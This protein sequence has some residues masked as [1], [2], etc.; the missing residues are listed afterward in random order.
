MALCGGTGE[1]AR[2][3]P[4]QPYPTSISTTPCRP[5]IVRG[6]VRKDAARNPR[7]RPHSWTCAEK[8]TLTSCQ[9]SQI[10]GQGV[11]VAVHMVRPED[12]VLV[13]MITRRAIEA[14]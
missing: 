7:I 6:L 8:R 5:G 4:C 10:S 14:V 3:R 2:W 1:L 9:R 11:S 13:R 12:L